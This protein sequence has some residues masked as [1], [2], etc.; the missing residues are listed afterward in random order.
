VERW[1][2]EG[3]ETTFLKKKF[4]SIQDSVGNEEKGYLVPD[5]D[6]CH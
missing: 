5:N 1:E 3:I 6:K 2:E 4:N